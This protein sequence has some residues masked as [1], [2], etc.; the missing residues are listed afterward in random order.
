MTASKMIK[1]LL[2]VTLFFVLMTVL[3][4]FPLALQMDTHI[5]GPFHDTDL[6]GAVW[7]L[8]WYQQA[9]RQGLDARF[10]P[11]IAAPFGV[12]LSREP[13]ASSVQ[14]FL[15]GL[16]TWLSPLAC[17]NLMALLSL[18][19]TGVVCFLL[20]RHVTGHGGA[21]LWA[22]VA[23]TFSPYHMNK[24]AQFGFFFIGS[25]FVLFLYLLTLAIERRRIGLLVLTGLSLGITASFSPYYG[26]FG[27]I[28]LAVY[29]VFESCYAWRQREREG[30]RLLDVVLPAA[31]STAVVAAVA[32]V[33]V[34]P[35]V[36]SV[37]RAFFSGGGD[38]P[39]AAD[40]GF[41]RPFKYLFAQSAR[42][43]SY[44][45][46]AATHPLFGGFTK[47]M[48]GSFFYGRGS[49]EQTLYVGWIPILLG[50]SAFREWRRR[51]QFGIDRKNEQR[52]REDAFIGLFLLI[53]VTALFL[54]MPPYMD[55]YLFRV[56]LPSFFIHKLLPMFRAYGRFGMVVMLSVSVLAGFGVKFVLKRLRT[57]QARLTFTALLFAGLLFEFTN[58]PPWRTTDISVPPAVYRWLGRQ[59]SDVLIAEYPMAA[60]SPGEAQAEYKYQFF[61]TFHGKRLVNGAARGTP[62]F[63]VK[64][65]VRRVDDP[66]T[67]GILK[68]LGA[69]Y[70]IVHTERYGSGWRDDVAIGGQAPRVRNVPGYRFVRAF[71]PAE[72]Y[73]IVGPAS[74]KD[75]EFIERV[76]RLS[77]ETR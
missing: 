11:L 62:A 37:V 36:V 30:R 43:L 13:V 15:R 27:F 12:D 73:E 70:V 9:A 18:I 31:V 3:A 7:H 48:F 8:W 57:K 23:F 2:A 60:A 42:P 34:A 68:A 53:G 44:L 33:F 66:G 4:T 24:L 52:V 64:E 58:I 47:K 28:L 6:R 22:A 56:Y 54:S 65:A 19:M 74:D 10:C 20:V 61:Q 49:I 63:K 32:A 14:W 59:P 77:G 38:A 41:D 29:G 25:W 75:R 67:P 46:P 40:V 51:R 45:L 55:F 35:L 21:A 5:Y 16:L 26:F 50:V 17:L 71:G 69:R 1:P 76:A 39:T 72:V